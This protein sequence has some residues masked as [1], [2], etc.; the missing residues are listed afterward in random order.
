[1][2][3]GV[4]R[5]AFPGPGLGPT[6]CPG[7]LSP[8]PFAGLRRPWMTDLVDGH[9]VIVYRCTLCGHTIALDVTDGRVRNDYPD[10]R[11]PRS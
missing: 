11:R 1:V 10:P 7:E 9:R 3:H 5:A 2:R 6:D 4:L 8:V